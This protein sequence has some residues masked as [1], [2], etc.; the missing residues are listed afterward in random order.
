MVFDNQCRIDQA[1]DAATIDL[2]WKSRHTKA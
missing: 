2:I 1:S